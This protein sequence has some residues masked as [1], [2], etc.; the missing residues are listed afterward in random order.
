MYAHTVVPCTCHESSVQFGLIFCEQS[1]VQFD[2]A[3]SLG[4]V[5]IVLPHS[6]PEQKPR[7]QPTSAKVNST[8]LSDHTGDNPGLDEQPQRLILN[9]SSVSKSTASVTQDPMTE[10]S[11][12]DKKESRVK[13]RKTSRLTKSA[14]RKNRKK[15]AKVKTKPKATKSSF[16]TSKPQSPRKVNLF[17]PPPK[18]NRVPKPSPRSC[19][20]DRD[21]TTAQSA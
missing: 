11:V 4:N 6:F 21:T 12:L 13:L 7:I 17:C 3:D 20:H 8:S 1:I 9:E 2:L 14:P 19:R 10:R 15:S 5:C 18:K 16:R